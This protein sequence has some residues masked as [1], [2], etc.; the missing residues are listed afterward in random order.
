MKKLVLIQ[1]K[2][3][4]KRKAKS[5]NLTVILYKHALSLFII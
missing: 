1:W 2:E 4:V 3:R 5:I